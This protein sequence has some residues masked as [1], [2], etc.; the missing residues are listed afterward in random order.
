[1]KNI[2]KKIAIGLVAI[3]VT[4]AL[5]PSISGTSIKVEKKIL[6]QDKLVDVE[7]Y[8][9]RVNGI[10]ETIK[11]R[12]SK[13][14]AERL[15]NLIEEFNNALAKVKSKTEI[16]KIFENFLDKLK[17]GGFLTD[18]IKKIFCFTKNF[19]TGGLPPLMP[20]LLPPKTVWHLGSFIQSFGAGRVDIPYY[21]SRISS[22][23]IL[24]RPIWWQYGVLAFTKITDGHIIMPRFD[25]YIMFGRH[26]G[27]MLGFIGLYVKI[28]RLILRDIHF[29]LG[30]SP[31]I[32][33]KDYGLSSWL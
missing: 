10:I 31:L 20:G 24:L 29:F 26:S 14:K 16:C 30:W 12:M 28:P 22:K 17:V 7:Y 27:F 6:N 11:M 2:N 8:F 4:T 13:E 5:L 32:K 18:A 1:M 19:I 23:G 9:F 33:T 3:F 21:G 25:T 15:V